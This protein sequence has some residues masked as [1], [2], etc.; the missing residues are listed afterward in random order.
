MFCTRIT[1]IL[2]KLFVTPLLLGGALLLMGS[3]N[4]AASRAARFYPNVPLLN[5]DGKTLRF[6]DDVIKGKVV[7][8]NFMFTSC[9][10]S[11]PLE[12]AKLLEVQKR[13]GEHV[14]KNVYMY[15]ISVDPDRDTPQALKAYMKKFKVGPG[16]QFLT[17]K[18]EDID[19]IRKKLG[20]YVEGENELSDHSISF[21]IGNEATGRWVKRSPF[22]VPEALV[23]VL[24]G[25]MQTRSLLSTVKRPDYA[26]VPKKAASI[27]GEDLFI[28]RCTI[29]H[30]IGKGRKVGPDLLGVVGSLDLKWLIRWLMEP[31]VVLKEKDP[32][33][34]ALFEQ[35][36]KVPMPNMRLS[37][38]DAIDLI[39]FL[40]V[41]SKRAMEEK[42]VSNV[43]Q[44]DH[45]AHQHSAP[46]E[47]EPKLDDHGDHQQH[48]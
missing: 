11:C 2:L 8:I 45:S 19:L 44:H 21:V 14:G 3:S 6:Y 18:Q 10:D 26:S 24:L 5:Q 42:T 47:P 35:Y 4:A 36:G 33:A 39:Y 40:Q 22:D 31:D 37:E 30:S 15:S 1:A 12:T 17:G 20:M 28:T 46:V 29:C 34:T 13:L 32:L 7:T 16:W 41:E 23:T 38:Q 27:P 9:V 43:P 48:Q 25:R